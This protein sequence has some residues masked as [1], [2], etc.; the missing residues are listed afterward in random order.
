[1][2]NDQ[3]SYG[4]YAGKILRVDLGRGKVEMDETSRYLPDWIGGRGLGARIGWDE[5]PPGTGAFDPVSPL[6]ILPG[7]LTGTAAPFSGRTTVCG[8]APQGFPEEYFTRS[9]FGGRW[10]SG[11]KYAGFD[12]IVITGRADRPVYLRI[13]DGKAEIRDGAGLKGLGL[14]EK[15][16]KILAAEGKDWRIFAIGPAG[17]NLSRIAVG[18]TETESASGQGGFGAVMGSKNLLAVAVRGE[19]P[20]AIADPERF[21]RVCRL[22][23]EEAHGSHGWPHTPRLDPEK[24]KKYGQRFQACTEGCSIRCFDARSYRS[25]PGTLC[26]KKNYSGQVDCIAQLFPGPKETWYNWDIGFEAGFEIGYISNDLGL[27]HWELLVGMIPWLRGLAARGELKKIDRLPIDF[28]SPAFW[29]DLLEKIAYRRGE[30]GDALAEGTVRAA[31]RL[32]LGLDLVDEFYPARGYAG[33]WDGHG[34]H[35]NQVFFPFWIV[36]A[37]QWALDTRDPISSAHGYAQNIMG[38]SPYCSPEQGLSWERI[39]EVAARVYGTKEAAHP[40]SGYAAKEI[41]AVF[42]MTRSV[43]KD[44]LPLGDQ[45]F[46]RIYS[47]KT[48]DNFARAGE[49]EGPSFEYHLLDAATGFGWSEAEFEGAARRVLH[50][51]RA[52][53]ARNFGRGRKEDEAVIPYFSRPENLVNPRIGEKVSLE[54][55]KFRG[56]LDRVYGRLGW[57]DDGR[58]TA[59]TLG[60]CGL[61]F[62]AGDVSGELPGT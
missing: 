46:P 51:E 34:D 3:K 59:E 21:A 23:R 16:K 7:P 60:G 58:P 5:I 4:G 29:K 47:K 15:Q 45:V 36:S 40:E 50:L 56:L 1:M 14:I 48:P 39:A 54:P 6:M 11:L 10:G 37:L 26:P 35:I 20:L 25:V 24:V 53:L 30:M 2:S 31:R 49:M 41:P 44:S 32:G 12:G 18:A 62:A 42:H 57:G 19:R 52:L 33:H 61:G 13:E 9:S 38:W 17:E 8:L 22:V 27:N 28:S 55:E 43:I